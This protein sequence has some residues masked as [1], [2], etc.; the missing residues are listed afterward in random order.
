M[1]GTD[2]AEALPYVEKGRTAA[3]GAS[4][5]GYLVDWIAGHTDR[6]Q[7]ARLPRRRLRPRSRCTARPRSCGSPE[8]EFGGRTGQAARCTSAGARSGFVKS[9]KTP[10]LVVHGELDYRVPLEQGLGMFTALQR[11]GVPSR[12]HR[13]P[14]REPLGAEARQLACAGTRKSG[15]ASTAGSNGRRR[16]GRSPTPGALGPRG[17]PPAGTTRATGSARDRR[18]ST[19][20]RSGP[21]IGGTRMRAYASDDG[22]LL[23]ALRLARAMTCKS[24][25]GRDALRRR[26]GRDRGRSRARQDGGAPDRVRAGGRAPRRAA[27]TAAATWA[28]T[29]A[30]SRSCPRDAPCDIS[31]RGRSGASTP[32][33]SP[34]WACSRRIESGGRRARRAPRAACAWPSRAWARWAAALARRLAAAGRAAHRGRHR[35][36]RASSAPAERA[37]RRRS[38]VARGDLRRRRPTCFSPNA[39]GRRARRR[40]RSPRLRCR[41]VVGAANEQL[42]DDA[43]TATRCTRAGSCY[44]PDYVANAGGL[45]SVL[46]R[47]RRA[48]TRRA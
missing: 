43:R 18:A 1:R 25:D 38:S 27:S 8:W 14:R 34:P 22:A 16:E 33:T 48:A 39:A 46:V 23:D 6:Y 15:L 21:P 19:T 13:L 10:T 24:R 26:Q 45:L 5:G 4:Y 17:G 31:A 7:R 37:G 2:Y 20:P 3:A 40:P 42:A 29:G 9:F 36:R 11:Q 30:T 28:W 41:A 12:L 47:D 32:P 44:A 35:R